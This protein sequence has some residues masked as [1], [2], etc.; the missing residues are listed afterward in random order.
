MLAE[1]FKRQ[2]AKTKQN[3]YGL[4]RWNNLVYEP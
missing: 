2:G 4:I 3:Q 1:P